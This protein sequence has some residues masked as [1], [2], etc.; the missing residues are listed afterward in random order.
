MSERPDAASGEK[1]SP[2]RIAPVTATGVPKP[3][4]PSRQEALEH[5][6]EANSLCA[7]YVVRANSLLTYA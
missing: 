6:R 3:E 7:S 2:I 5:W 1:P 4:A